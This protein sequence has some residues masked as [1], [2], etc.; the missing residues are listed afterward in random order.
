VAFAETGGDDI[1]FS[2][3]SVNDRVSDASAVV[4]T[5]PSLGKTPWDANV[6]VGESLHGFLSLGCRLGYAAIEQ[7][8]YDWDEA[9]LDLE[10]W[11]NVET[12]PSS[13]KAL[14]AYRKELELEPWSDPR[15]RL[16]TLE[17]GKRFVL[18]FR[19]A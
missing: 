9:V 19:M 14:R 16:A 4:M 18:R 6:M 8:A 1:H 7:L 13:E 3:V 2:L 5:V 12:E 11:R 17:Q 10:R 15:R